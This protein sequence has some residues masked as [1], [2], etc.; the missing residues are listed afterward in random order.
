[1]DDNLVEYQNQR[2]VMGWWTALLGGRYMMSWETLGT[3]LDIVTPVILELP[4]SIEMPYVVTL[5]MAYL[6]SLLAPEWQGA[7]DN[8]MNQGPYNDLVAYTTLL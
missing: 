7:A 6:V 8:L 2:A 1:M 4:P 5:Q 3:F